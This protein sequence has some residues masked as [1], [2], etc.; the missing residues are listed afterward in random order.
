MLKRIILSTIGLAA[1][2]IAAATVA[3]SVPSIGDPPPDCFPFDCPQPNDP[4][5]T[6]Q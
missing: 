5:D 4:P 3:P 2:T 1:L 6:R